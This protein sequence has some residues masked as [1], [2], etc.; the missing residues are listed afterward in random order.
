MD[1]RVGGGIE[2]LTVLITVEM[3][4]VVIPYSD[5]LVIPHCGGAINPGDWRG[6]VARMMTTGIADAINHRGTSYDVTIVT[7]VTTNSSTI[8][9]TTNIQQAMCKLVLLPV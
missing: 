3:T 8:A 6:I 7:T 9:S 5:P 2:H 1:L 4:I